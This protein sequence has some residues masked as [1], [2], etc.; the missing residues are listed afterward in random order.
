M[1]SPLQHCIKLEMEK[2][3]E[4]TKQMMQQLM[5]ASLLGDMV[6]G[7]RGRGGDGKGLIHFEHTRPKMKRCG[8]GMKTF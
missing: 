8:P 7:R 4:D 5:P 1:S 2:A 3:L 6:R